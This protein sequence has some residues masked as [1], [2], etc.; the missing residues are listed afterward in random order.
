VG[1]K[2][3]QEYLVMPQRTGSFTLPALRFAYLDPREG[4]YQVSETTAQIISVKPGAKTPAGPQAMQGTPPQ[5]TAKN[6]LAANGPRPLRAEAEFSTSTLSASAERVL[7]YSLL[8]APLGMYAAASFVAR[9]RRRAGRDDPETRARERARVAREGLARARAL[10]EGPADAFYTELERAVLSSLERRVGTPVGGLQRTE[11]LERLEA[12]GYPELLRA[13][14]V[15]LLEACE[16][17]RYAPGMGAASRVQLVADA[18][19]VI[20]GGEA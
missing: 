15:G 2:R 7:L 9:A 5:T 1:G 13:R 11:L 18:S 16:A 20:A 19:A 12:S 3:V 4:H 17:A 14:V 6:V 8:G 10:A